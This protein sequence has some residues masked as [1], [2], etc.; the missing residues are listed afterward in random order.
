[1]SHLDDTYDDSY[2]WPFCDCGVTLLDGEDQ[3]PTCAGA[4]HGRDCCC[5]ECDAYWKRICEE[6]ARAAYHANRALVC[7][8]GWTGAFIE[9]HNSE[10]YGPIANYGCEVTYRHPKD[11]RQQLVR[12][13][14]TG[15]EWR[16]V[17]EAHHA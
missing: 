17:E 11:E 7:S 13:V 14:W 10:A 3:C 8:C 5:D 12:K 16:Q 4:P 9:H 2:D 6:S 15:T 1:M